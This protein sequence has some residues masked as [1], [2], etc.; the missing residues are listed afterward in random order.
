MSTMIIT[1][2]HDA[3][4]FIELCIKGVHL[5]TKDPYEHLIIDNGSQPITIQMLESFSKKHW[6]KLIRRNISKKASGHADSLNW[7]LK[8]QIAEYICLLDSDAYPIRDDWFSF[9][10]NT[11]NY[12]NAD[13]VGFPHFRDESLLHPACMLFKYQAFAE[14]GRPTFYIRNSSG[15]FWDTAMIMGHKLKESGKKLVPIKNNILSEYVAHRW[16][17]TRIENEHR[18]TL[19]GVI[20]KDQFHRETEE[21]FKHNSAIEAIEHI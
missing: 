2:N 17:G 7:I 1:V 15:K 6:I 16:C 20:P 8:T 14:C 13:A 11:L 12:N 4:R 5:R 19:D 3:H 9:L 18:P 21:W 10:M